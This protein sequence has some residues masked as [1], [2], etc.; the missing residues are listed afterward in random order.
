[1]SRRFIAA[2][3]PCVVLVAGCMTHSRAPTHV[4]LVLRVQDGAVWVAPVDIPRYQCLDGVF[5]C[6]DGGGR[7]T[8]RQCRCVAR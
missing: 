2:V 5:V 4:D 3:A 1:M 8:K 6:A 7:L